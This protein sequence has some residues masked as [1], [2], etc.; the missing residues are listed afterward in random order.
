MPL[1]LRS[2]L[3]E[4]HVLQTFATVLLVYEDNHGALLMASAV[5]PTTQSRHINYLPSF[6][7]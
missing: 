3:D 2:I 1:Y 7:L 4:L 6:Y 5:Q